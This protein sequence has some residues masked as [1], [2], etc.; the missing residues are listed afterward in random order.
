MPRRK[1]SHEPAPARAACRSSGVSRKSPDHTRPAAPESSPQADTPQA[2]QRSPSNPAVSRPS[3]A[4]AAW[5]V[6][7][8]G[9]RTSYHPG[10]LRDA[11]PG[12]QNRPWGHYQGFPDGI[13][14]FAA[15]QQQPAPTPGIGGSGVAPRAST[16]GSTK[17]PPAA[18]SNGRPIGGSGGRP[19]G[20]YCGPR[21]SCPRQR[22]AMAGHGMAASAVSCAGAALRRRWRGAS[23][24]AV[25][26]PSPPHSSRP[27]CRTFLAGKR[28]K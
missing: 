23:G 11:R 22:A 19:P 3:A 24:D 18:S 7:C 25:R 8:A 13:P 1:C 16:A 4:Q 5:P 2:S 17:L 28:H 6:A 20:Q 14:R 12:R 21:R 27:R 26:R 10:T 15:R 9:S